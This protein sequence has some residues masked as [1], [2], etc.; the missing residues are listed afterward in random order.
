M[1]NNKRQKRKIMRGKAKITSQKS[2]R[3]LNKT[4]VAK[5]APPDILW[6][7]RKVGVSCGL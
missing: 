1:E 2:K 7:I 4:I 6:G 3:I 5:K